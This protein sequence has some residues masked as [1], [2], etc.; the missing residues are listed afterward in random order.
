MLSFSLKTF[1]LGAGLAVAASLGVAT[2]AFAETEITFYHYQSGGNYEA[3]RAIL[4]DFEA[5][6]EGIEVKD[7]FA[8]SQQITAEVQAALAAGRPVDVAT[9]IG[10]NIVYFLNNTDAVD[11][12]EASKGDTGWL[13]GYLPNFLDL[14]RVDDAVY[15]IP[16]AYGTPMLYYN[17]A[18]FAE[19]GLDPETPPTTWAEFLAAGK[20][21][22][23]K[24]GKPGGAHLH[25]SMGDY[26]TMVMV[27]NA[28]AT[29]LNADG[30]KAEFDSPEGI[31]ALQNWQDMAK[32][33]MMPIATDRDWS[34]AFMGGQMG[35]YITSSAALRSA[36][37]ASE[38]K[39]EL[40]IANYPLFSDAPRRVNNS[41][42]ALMLYSKD[43]EKQAASMALLRFISQKEIANRWS[44]ASGY[45]PVVQDPLSDPAMQEYVASFPY[46]E[47]VITQMSQTVPTNVW[48]AKG[49]LEA[50]T[51]I[52]AMLDELWAAKRPASEIVPEAVAKVND[53]LAVNR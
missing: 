25:A 46:L 15:A 42:A 50:Q 39:F 34:G 18:I 22:T 16:H 51:V 7:I 17:R 6:N 45:M 38:G 47:P 13:D 40:G 8:Q 21:I 3:F 26:G 5:Q 2:G 27:T 41:G 49:T 14:G 53:A 31:A 20:T 36:V 10:K 11:L 9:V 43:A 23:E 1:T 19:A 28:G 48:P 29:Y 35:M 30:T 33:G 24:T 52:R 37:D 12:V 32:N 4:D 44:R